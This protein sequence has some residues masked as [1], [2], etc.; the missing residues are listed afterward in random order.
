MILGNP[1]GAKVK[2]G[3]RVRALSVEDVAILFAY[4]AEMTQSI[5]LAFSRGCSLGF[6][7]ISATVDKIWARISVFFFYS[8]ANWDAK[9]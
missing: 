1:G 4:Q 3:A 2:I 8:P 6:Q 5:T 7:S 9:F